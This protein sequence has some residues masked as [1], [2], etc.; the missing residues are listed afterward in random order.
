MNCYK[1]MLMI[2]R[3][4]EDVFKF[5]EAVGFKGN[6]KQAFIIKPGE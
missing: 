5:Y 4:Q 1:F 6:K 3:M 2:G